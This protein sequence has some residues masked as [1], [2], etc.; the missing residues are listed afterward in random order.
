MYQTLSSTYI[1]KKRLSQGPNILTEMLADQVKEECG[2]VA[3]VCCFLFIYF[4]VSL[5]TNIA[6]A[7]MDKEFGSVLSVELLCVGL[8]LDVFGLFT[9]SLGF[10]SLSHVKTEY[11][12]RYV[13]ATWFFCVSYVLSW[14]C[15]Y[16]LCYSTINHNLSTKLSLSDEQV[17]CFLIIVFL[18][19]SLIS[20]LVY[21]TAKNFYLAIQDWRAY[22]PNNDGNYR[23]PMILLDR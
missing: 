5:I 11:V 14:L 9:A 23:P 21:T 16:A 13:D 2:N 19:I 6:G 4:A 12:Q 18:A 3:L 10:Y 22:T 17:F 15:E 1:H 20:A 7:L 8:V